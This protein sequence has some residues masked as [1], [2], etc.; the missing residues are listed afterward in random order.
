MTDERTRKLDEQRAEAWANWQHTFTLDAGLE[1]YVDD[2][3]FGASCQQCDW[4]TAPIHCR[5]LDELNQEC[6]DHHATHW[7]QP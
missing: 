2:P 4:E 1:N 7:K 6:E 5:R 3:W